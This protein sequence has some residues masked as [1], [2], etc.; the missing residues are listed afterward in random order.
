MWDFIKRVISSFLG[1]FIALGLLSLIGLL[2]LIGV[3][4]AGDAPI[5]VKDKSVLHL[6]LNKEIVNKKSNNPLDE[7]SLPFVSSRKKHGLVS[8]LKAIDKAKEDPK[9]KAVYLEVENV[10]AGYATIEDIRNAL[11]E[12]KG[13]GKEVIAFGEIMTEKSYY[14]ASVASKIYLSPQGAVEFKGL[15]SEIMFFKGLFEKLGVQ[16]KIFRVGKF[17]SAVEPYLRENMSEENRLQIR[18]FLENIYQYN[19][20]EIAE[21]RNIDTQKLRQISDSLWV[22]SVEDAV[23]YNLIDASFYK[24]E[25]MSYL[26]TSI[27]AEKDKKVQLVSFEKYIRGEKI[28]PDEEDK[29]AVIVAEGAIMS[30]TNTKNTMGSVTICKSF[31]KARKDTTI[32]AV[33]LRI[34]SPGGSALASDVMWREI[35]LT[36]Q[37]KPVIASMGDVAASGGYYIAMGCDTIVAQA[38]T[39]TGSIGVFGMLFNTQKLLNEKIGITT[40]R[41]T[42]GAYSDIGSPT[43]PM[44]TKEEQIIQTGVE[45]V[46]ETFVTKAAE[47]RGMNV[48]ELKS[49]AG[50]RVWSGVEAESNG[51]VDVLGGLETA[52]HTAATKAK[53]DDYNLVYYPRNEGFFEELTE[54]L[55]ETQEQALLRKQLGN[56]YSYYQMLEAVSEGDKIQTRMPYELIL[57]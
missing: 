46:Y 10:Q 35:E 21:A 6:K 16:P 13:T 50:G 17:K 23:K 1:S 40:D 53:L 29:I 43:R 49:L 19:L 32:K 51:L 42:T 26:K 7:I 28:I 22:Q 15:A 55:E 36:K 11:K 8:I 44:L 31:E 24:D 4:S 38:N 57:E 45:K 9:I 12:F 14:L 54:E 39:I 56:Y 37:V 18:S 27:G 20:G 25:V 41:V 48:E 47:G 5:V 3:A 33:V 34:N 2:I 30:G 52:I